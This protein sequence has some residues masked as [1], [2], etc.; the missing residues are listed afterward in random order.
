MEVAICV[1]PIT[2]ILL[3]PKNSILILCF[4]FKQGYGMTETCGIVSVENP[5]K[6][7]V[8]KYGSTGK[9]A[10]CMEAKVVNV[11]TLKLLPPNVV[12]ELCFRGPNIMKGKKCFQFLE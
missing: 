1:W 8:R 11:D 7:E 2:I 10:P 3:L 9:L 12:G 6:G 4:L 5:I